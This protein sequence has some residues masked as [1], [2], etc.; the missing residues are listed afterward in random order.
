MRPPENGRQTSLESIS[1]SRLHARNVFGGMANGRN[2]LLRKGVNPM[3]ADLWIL[4]RIEDGR[5]AVLQGED[6]QERIVP[7]EA[8]PKGVAEG[9]VLR[10][11]QEA[12]RTGPP[13]S[14]VRY[15][16]DRE[17]TARRVA[18]IQELRASLPRGPSGPLSL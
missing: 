12:G 7:L 3:T 16:A 8:L 15:V 6:G 14:P 17:A 1:Y 18:G 2:P 9:T 13:G 5:Q 11:A 10:E 4:D